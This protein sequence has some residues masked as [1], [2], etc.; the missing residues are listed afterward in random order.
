MLPVAILAG[1][2]GRRLHPLTATVPKALVPV[3]GR[4]FVAHQLDLLASQGIA[5]A[6]LCVGHLG[7]QIRELVGDGRRFGLRVEYSFDG[8]LPLGTGGALRQ[9]LPLLGEGCFVLYGDSYLT[10]AFDAVS[11][12]FRN[13]R[14]A[15]LLTVLRNANRWDRSNA[16][17]HAD[18]Q[19]DYDKTA[20]RSDMTHIDYGLAVLA[21]SV[22]EAIP[23]GAI[24]LA[25][26][27]RGLSR[28][29][30]LAGY[31]V[32]ERFYEIGSAAGLADTECFLGQRMPRRA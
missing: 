9:A 8:P 18:G 1:G 14:Q 2:L 31:E 5:R 24:D 19:V 22:L 12:A 27:Y 30:A 11:A 7:E 29:G 10:C 4:P 6:V 23:N 20:N 17:L 32:T 28:R 3:A 13:S 21:R 25:V 26:V 16:R 15:A